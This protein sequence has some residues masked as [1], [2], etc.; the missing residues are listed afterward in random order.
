MGVEDRPNVK[1][2]N[3]STGEIFSGY[4]ITNSNGSITS[5]IRFIDSEAYAVWGKFKGD[6]NDFFLQSE[7]TTKK[8]AG[9]TL[10]KP[11]KLFEDNFYVGYFG[12]DA[13][14]ESLKEFVPQEKLTNTDNLAI[15]RFDGYFGSFSL[16]RFDRGKQLDFIFSTHVKSPNEIAEF[17]SNYSADQVDKDAL[18][19]VLEEIK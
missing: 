6:A 14:D 15:A 10:A 7:E 8:L 5:V 12:E 19:D 3:Q 18:V 9:L 16:E 2:V 4:K 11:K 1:K 17:I 13:Q